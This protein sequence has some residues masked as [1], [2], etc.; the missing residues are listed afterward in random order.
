MPKPADDSPAW[1]DQEYNNDSTNNP[2]L[3]RDAINEEEVVNENDVNIKIIE[4]GKIRE[5]YA[6]RLNKKMSQPVVDIFLFVN[7]LSGSRQG[8]KLLDLKDKT[9]QFEL[10]Q[11]V[12][13]LSGDLKSSQKKA[14]K[15]FDGQGTIV[16]TRIYNLI[17]HDEKREALGL[18][19]TIQ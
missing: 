6:D 7:P 2:R 1:K 5:E 3:H 17:D 15:E 16:N 13:F 8:Q 19:Q 11:H 18:L 9:Y 12:E 14:S 4:E 10:E